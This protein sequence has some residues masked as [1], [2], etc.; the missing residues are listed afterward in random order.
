MVGSLLYVVTGQ[1]TSGLPV[2]SATKPKEENWQWLF[3]KRGSAALVTSTLEALAVLIS[4]KV[5]YGDEPPPH[6]EKV[7]VAP[8]WTDNRGNGLGVEQAHVNQIPFKRGV[9][10]KLQLV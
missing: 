4:L 6:Q 2:V 3:E 5:F 8:T 10:G 7:V 9:D 1:L